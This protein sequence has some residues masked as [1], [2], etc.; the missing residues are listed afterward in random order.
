MPYILN[1]SEKSRV[2]HKGDRFFVSQVQGK[3]LC[4]QLI[5]ESDADA[6]I[7]MSDERLD[8][9]VADILQVARNEGVESYYEVRM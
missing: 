3:R 7:G 8:S 2:Y 1:K 4:R 9:T 5:E 6:L